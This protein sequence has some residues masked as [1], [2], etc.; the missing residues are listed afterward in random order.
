MMTRKAHTTLLIGHDLLVLGLAAYLRE[1]GGQVLVRDDLRHDLD[2]GLNGAVPSAIIIDL[3]V[4]RRDDFLLLRRLRGSARFAR[5]PIIV[6]STG[7]LGVERAGLEARLRSFDARPLLAPH[8]IDDV[9]GELERSRMS[10][11]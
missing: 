2:S 7:T 8:D 5:V 6:L 1:R 3:L 10:V 9:V 11:A 4:A